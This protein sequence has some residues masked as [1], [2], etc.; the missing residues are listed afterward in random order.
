ML[1]ICSSSVCMVLCKYIQQLQDIASNNNV[2]LKDM[3]IVAGV[4]TST[5]Y[6]AMN[7]MDLRFDTA[8]R[9]LE[10]FRH[11]Q[12]QSSTSSNQS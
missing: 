11:V 6:R 9:I 5:Y 8:Q 12:L 1:H 2:R 3:F 10:A 4:P 7:G